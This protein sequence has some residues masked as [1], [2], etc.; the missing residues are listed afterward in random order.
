MTSQAETRTAPST[1]TLEA[2]LS[3]LAVL[4]VLLTP[5]SLF[6]GETAVLAWLWADVALTWL[7]AVLVWTRSGNGLLSLFVPFVAT[8]M[9]AAI[10]AAQPDAI[11]PWPPVAHAVALVALALGWRRRGRKSRIGVR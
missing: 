6:L 10:T 7:A 5:L 9:V 2:A 3:G 8:I 4:F 1:T 11:G